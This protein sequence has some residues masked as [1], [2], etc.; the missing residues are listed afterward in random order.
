MTAHSPQLQPDTSQSVRENPLVWSEKTNVVKP[1]KY[2]LTV[3]TFSVTWNSKGLFPAPLFHHDFLIEVSLRGT[4]SSEIKVKMSSGHGPEG[5]LGLSESH[6]WAFSLLSSFLH[7]IRDNNSPGNK[8]I[9]PFC[10]RGI[11]ASKV[12]LQNLSCT[13][14]RNLKIYPKSFSVTPRS[15]LNKH[16]IQSML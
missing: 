10:H 4:L 3:C 5:Q 9:W 6:H 8:L 15:F 2:E 7:Q 13:L 11:T 12:T 14:K 1:N 16:K